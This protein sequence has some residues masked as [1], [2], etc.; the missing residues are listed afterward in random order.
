MRDE[1]PEACQ[2]LFA[3]RHVSFQPHPR[4]RPVVQIA[5]VGGSIGGR[6]R[7]G[8]A[9]Y[10]GS[11]R[12]RNHARHGTDHDSK[13][14]P[15]PSGIRLPSYPLR[16]RPE[17]RRSARAAAGR[18]GGGL[19]RVPRPAPG[20]DHLPERRF[21]FIPFWGILVFFLY[22]MWHVQCRNCG[23]VVTPEAKSQ[24][25]CRSEGYGPG[26]EECPP[27]SAS[28]I[29]TSTTLSSCGSPGG[30]CCWNHCFVGSRY[31]LLPPQRKDECRG[32]GDRDAETCGA[33]L[34][35]T[36]SSHFL[37]IHITSGRSFP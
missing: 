10:A 35:R 18:I 12:L 33:F 3:R 30:P 25:G 16:P 8:G 5:A 19:L 2:Q 21:E 36:T 23:V 17:K 11:L 24:R 32:P 6:R 14:L 9:G 29:A 1:G 37:G 4:A 7:C 34:L 22:S 31:K 28:K 15:P 27:S 26:D 20:Y 13:P